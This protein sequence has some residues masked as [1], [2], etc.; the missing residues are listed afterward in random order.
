MFN[1]LVGKWFHK[2]VKLMLLCQWYSLCMFFSGSKC[3]YKIACP[4]W[5]TRLAMPRR[6]ADRFR[7]LNW[8]QSFR[9]LNWFQSFRV[10]NWFQSFRVLNWFQS[11]ELVSEFQSSELVSEF[12]SSELVSEFWTGF[13]VSEFWS[14]SDAESL[15]EFSADSSNSIPIW[16]ATALKKKKVYNFELFAPI[17]FSR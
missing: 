10:L 13:R 17:T 12:Q 1:N 6:M 5:A 8:F 4:V 2:T 9:V 14:N 15:S 3:S 7:V 16:W 11:S